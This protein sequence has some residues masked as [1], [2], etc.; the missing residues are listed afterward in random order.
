MRILV[1]C[2]SWLDADP[3][4]ADH[5]WMP[6]LAGCRSTFDADPR[7]MPIHYRML[8]ETQLLMELPMLFNTL[9]LRETPSS[10]WFTI[11]WETWFNAERTKKE[12][13]SI[14]STDIIKLNTVPF[15]Y[16]NESVWI[17]SITEL[18]AHYLNNQR[19]IDSGKMCSWELVSYEQWSPFL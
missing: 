1:W 11:F 5:R 17:K 13:A 3:Q 7:L 2:R 15:M 16:C 4:I 10:Y 12:L 19:H 9:N 18:R 14:T 8:S 6:I